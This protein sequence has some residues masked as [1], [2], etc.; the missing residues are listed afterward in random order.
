MVKGGSGTPLFYEANGYLTRDS[1]GDYKHIVTQG[2]ME[3]IIGVMV[4]RWASNAG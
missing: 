1:R 3:A 4:N 2:A